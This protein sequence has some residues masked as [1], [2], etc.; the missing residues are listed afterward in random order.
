MK[1][2]AYA[3]PPVGEVVDLIDDSL[4]DIVDLVDISDD[5]AEISAPPSRSG[6]LSFV[7][8]AASGPSSS[9]VS[10]PRDER[11]K[12]RPSPDSDEDIH[13]ARRRRFSPAE[14]CASPAVFREPDGMIRV[15]H[16]PSNEMRM[17]TLMR[18]GLLIP[19]PSWDV[20]PWHVIGPRILNS[21]IGRIGELVA[22]R[23]YRDVALAQSD[24]LKVYWVN[25]HAETGLPFD[26]ILTSKTRQLQEGEVP[27]A[28]KC[29][30]AAKG[31]RM[32][33]IDP[34]DVIE[35]I[36]VKST[37]VANKSAFEI[38][39]C[40][41]QAAKDLGHRYTIL[42]VFGISHPHS[43]IDPKNPARLVSL[44][45]PLKLWKRRHIKVCAVMPDPRY[46]T[47]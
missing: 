38:S 16:T 47:R 33:G 43:P 23:Y 41:L 13:P 29:P 9:R 15:P 30:I 18:P 11:R 26:M 34:N 5:E 32:F 27:I 37:R 4:E 7:N 39:H 1:Q 31:A 36:E 3:W 28:T 20:P 19:P 21:L 24:H 42:R 46:L 22:Y 25:E 10:E 40:E 35:F 45:D 14:G 44:N 12:R 2:V 17:V 6:D 8:L